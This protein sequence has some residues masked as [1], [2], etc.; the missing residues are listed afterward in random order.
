MSRPGVYLLLFK[1]ITKQQ[2]SQTFE[3]IKPM[4]WLFKRITKQ[5]DSQTDK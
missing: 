2:D 5:Q 1:R 4:F 3:A